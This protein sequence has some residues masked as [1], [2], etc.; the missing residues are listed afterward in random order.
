MGATRF[1]DGTVAD[2]RALAQE[3]FSGE[4]GD[5]WRNMAVLYKSPTPAIHR[6]S[7]SGVG[8]RSYQMLLRAA[9]GRPELEYTPGVKL[10]GQPFG[11]D[12]AINYVDKYIVAHAKIPRDEMKVAH[13]DV[14]PDNAR[15]FARVIG[16]EADRRIFTKSCLAARATASNKTVQGSSL[17]VHNGGNRVTRTGGSL[18]AAYPYSSTGAANF[19]ADLRTLALQMDQDKIP[20][21]NR[22][23]YVRP[24]MINV[25]LYDTTAQV[26]SRDYVDAATNQIQ[27]RMVREVEGFQIQIDDLV[28]PTSSGGSLPDENILTG[29]TRYQA[30]FSIGASNGTPVAVA[31]CPG[32]AGGA[33]V[34]VG[35]WD[36]VANVIT[37]IEDEMCWFMMSALL[38]GVDQMYP[39]CVGSI[40]VIT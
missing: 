13:F 39:Y 17:N 12:E 6:K 20:R 38:M 25:L 29:P 24:E 30:D 7:M 10:L 35:T 18:T 37:Y 22:P 4:F 28:N 40:E 11:A 21:G 1:L 19:R 14:I 16:L 23:M 36:E 5:A 9:M 31:L 2:D 33:G 32:P 26:F 34:T 27:K 15:E 8:A 3:V